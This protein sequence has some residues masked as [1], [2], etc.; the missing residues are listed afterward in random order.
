[1]L[2]CAIEDPLLDII[3]KSVTIALTSLE[4]GLQTVNEAK[5]DVPPYRDERAVGACHFADRSS[6]FGNAVEAQSG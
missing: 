1:L 6:E 2:R 5:E 3:E 4:S